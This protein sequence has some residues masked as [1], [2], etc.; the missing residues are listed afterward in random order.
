[1]YWTLL[2]GFSRPK[3]SSFAPLA[4]SRML[5]VQMWA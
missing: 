3:S 1:M 2:A 5:T 4:V